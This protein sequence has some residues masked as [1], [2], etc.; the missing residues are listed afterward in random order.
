MVTT[1]RG[2]RTTPSPSALKATSGPRREEPPPVLTTSLR[3]SFFGK[4]K[5]FFLIYWSYVCFYLCLKNYGL[6][7]PPLM[8]QLGAS[9]AEAGLIGSAWQIASGVTKV[10]GGILVDLYSPRLILAGSLLGTFREECNK[11]RN[12]DFR[13]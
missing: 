7:L 9:K 8:E 10:F 5:A 13:D 4:W 1:R 12:S 11:L 6:F 2:A 3:P